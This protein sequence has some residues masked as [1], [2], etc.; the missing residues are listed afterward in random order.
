MKRIS[1]LM[2][3]AM[4]ILLSSVVFASPQQVELNETYSVEQTK[5]AINSRFTDDVRFYVPMRQVEGPNDYTRMYITYNLD[6]WVMAVFQNG[7]GY[8]CGLSMTVPDSTNSMALET[9]ATTLLLAAVGE[10][11]ENYTWSSEE[12]TQLCRARDNAKEYGRGFFY[13]HDTQRYYRLLTEHDRVRSQWYF[14][15]KAYAKE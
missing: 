1:I 8:V 5:A 13:C 10:D 3:S 11:A 7:P 15:V 2:V 14:E 12:M 9:I 6:E 4:M